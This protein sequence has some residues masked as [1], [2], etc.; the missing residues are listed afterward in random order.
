MVTTTVPAPEAQPAGISAIGRITGVLFSPKATFED[1]VRKPSWALPVIL[2]TVL[3]LC[4]SFAIN[5][6]INW[7]EYVGQ[8]IEKSPSA[9]NMSSEQKEQR[10][11]GGAKFSPLVT[12]AIGLFLPILATLVVALA[13]WGGFNLLGGANT[14]FSTSIGITSHAFLTGLV[15]SPLFILVLY[16]KPYGTVDLD[17]P[18]ATNVGAFLP[19]DTAKWL[20]SLG[21][22]IDVFSFWVLI[23]LAIG[24]ACT[25][26]RKLKGS[27]AFMIAFSIWAAYVVVKVGFTAILG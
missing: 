18:M 25:N 11:E 10:V 4:V 5:Q 16:L 14:N 21:K 15:S 2:I 26:P 23:L 7:R 22:S 19:E 27:K 12:Y 6:R 1:I 3:S 17:N 24:F 8:Q 9:A 13:M 20:M